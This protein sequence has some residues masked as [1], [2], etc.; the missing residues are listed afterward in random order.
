MKKILLLSDTHSYMDDRILDYASQ[1]DE[2]W[3]CGDF[4]NS[5]VIEK[6]EK[7]T[8]LR[9]V[10]GNIDGEKV[11]KIFPEVARFTVENVEVLMIHIGGY[12][13]KYS[14][15]AKKEIAEESPNLFISGHSH[16]LK[17]MFD[18]KNNLL[19]LNPGACG[20]EGW[21]KTRTMMRFEINGEKIENL[22]II[23]LGKR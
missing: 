4:G 17:A 2:I 10:Y 11:R 19:H 23:E 22:E 5:E 12:P 21:H 6:L 16:I 8:T 14:P 13:G 3:H 7:I 9:G 15:L 20:K 18:Q 1:A